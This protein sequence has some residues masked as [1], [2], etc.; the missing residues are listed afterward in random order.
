MNEKLQITL[1]ENICLEKSKSLAKSIIQNGM[2]SVL[3][4]TDVAFCHV[5]FQPVK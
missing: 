4:S 3:L 2:I 1:H 5:I